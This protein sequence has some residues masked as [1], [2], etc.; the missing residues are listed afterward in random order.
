MKGVFMQINNNS[1]TN[2]V[3]LGGYNNKLG[4][5]S[6]TTYGFPENCTI[7]GGKNNTIQNTSGIANI[8]GIGNT[9]ICSLAVTLP[10]EA[11]SCTMS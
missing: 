3:I 5:S 6:G 10:P 2:N 1:N 4:D 9:K 11:A 7:I 8:S